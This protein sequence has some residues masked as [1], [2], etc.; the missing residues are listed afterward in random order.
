MKE[1]DRTTVDVPGDGHCLVVSVRQSLAVKAVHFTTVEIC[2]E[3][4][5][6]IETNHSL[7]SAFSSGQ[8]ILG[9]LSSYIEDNNYNTD[10]SDLLVDGLANALKLDITIYMVGGENVRKETHSPRDGN[11]DHCIEVAQYGAGVGAHYDSVQSAEQLA[12]DEACLQTPTKTTKQKEF[13]SPFV[14]RQ[15]PKAGPRNTNSVNRR[16]R[17]TAILTDTPEKEKLQEQEQKRKKNVTK[18]K[19]LPAKRK[20]KSV[21][22]KVKQPAEAAQG[23]TSGSSKKNRK[24]KN[25]SSESEDSDVDCLICGE[26][27]STSRPREKWVQCIDCKMWAHVLCTPQDSL[28]AYSC[29][30]CNSDD[31]L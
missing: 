4:K 30:N 5:K 8:D 3:L 12:N 29:Q 25:V 1:N 14:I 21:L 23:N 16:R 18:M 19:A 22:R 28:Y 20:T 7:Y 2:N 11:I 6:E 26:T 31:N 9:D 13:V 10:T 17:H 27:F 24:R 15:F